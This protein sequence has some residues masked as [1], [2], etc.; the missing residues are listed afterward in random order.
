LLLRYLATPDAKA[1]WTEHLGK[2]LDDE[3]VAGLLLRDAARRN[4]QGVVLFTTTRPERVGAAVDAVAAP[5]DPAETAA[6]RAMVQAATQHES[7]G[8]T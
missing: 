5:D 4:P 8:S 3:T 6:L 2:P 7:G 1:Q